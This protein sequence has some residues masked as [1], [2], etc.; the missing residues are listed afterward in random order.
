MWREHLGEG[1]S[2]VGGSRG[3]GGEEGGPP[4]RLDRVDCALLGLPQVR[5]LAEGAYE[6]KHVIHA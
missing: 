2:G 1:V 3:E 4:S 5:C 6:H